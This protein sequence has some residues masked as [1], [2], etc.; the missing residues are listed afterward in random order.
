MIAQA[1]GVS[2]DVVE[3]IQKILGWPAIARQIQ[4]AKHLVPEELIH[5]ITASGTPA[6]ARAKV[7]EYIDH[8]CTC[9]ILYGVGGNTELLI[10][11]FAKE[12]MEKLPG[13]SGCYVCRR[14]NPISL[15]LEFLWMK[16]GM[17]S[18]NSVLLRTMPAIRGWFMVVTSWL[19]WMKP[20]AEQ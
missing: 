20:P 6:E 8:G 18:L 12:L 7:Q 1:S 2:M 16:T 5:R 9:P 15:K 10:D 14:D 11:T 4:A 13:S 3:N 19:F 17:L